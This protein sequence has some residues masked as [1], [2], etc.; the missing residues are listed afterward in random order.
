MKKSK[1]NSKTLIVD[2]KYFTIGLEILNEVIEYMSLDYEKKSQNEINIA[3]LEFLYKN[4]EDLL[5]AQ[6]RLYSSLNESFDY[7]NMQ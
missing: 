1:D 2:K 3:E 7:E 6:S 4:I 5:E